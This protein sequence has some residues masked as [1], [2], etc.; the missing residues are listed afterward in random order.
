[1]ALA[2]LGINLNV[3]QAVNSA[4][5]LSRSLAG[6]RQTLSGLT[7]PFVGG[8]GLASLF[9]SSLIRS[10]VNAGRATG[11][12]YRLSQGAHNLQ[13]ALGTV[14]LDALDSVAPVLE[15]FIRLITDDIGNPTLLG[16]I[17]TLGGVV[18]ALAASAVF[19]A[20]QLVTLVSGVLKGISALFGKTAATNAD[21]AATG[22]NT[23]AAAAN[24]AASNA[25][26]AAAQ[27]QSAAMLRLAAARRLAL[28]AAQGA[29]RGGPA[30]AIIGGGLGLLSL[31]GIGLAVN[32]AVRASRPAPQATRL[33]GGAATS[34]TY[35]PQSFSGNPN[36]SPETPII[37]ETRV[38]LDGDVLGRSSQEYI[39]RNNQ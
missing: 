7:L 37:I 20:N 18:S 22:R 27:R 39:N 15:W 29:L 10:A 6:V 28:G 21:T 13:V 9:G 11:S 25:Q 4:R 5:A 38:D 32:D 17:L 12:Y 19:A 8:A 16:R 3:T 2:R 14:L 1:M 30:G 24:I 33:P 35:L 26:T 23:A 36:V 31:A 34:P